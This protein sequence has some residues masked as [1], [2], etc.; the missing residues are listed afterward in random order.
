[1]VN[2]DEKIIM[3][4]EKI[5]F[6]DEY[7]ILEK[8]RSGSDGIVYKVT[9][10]DTKDLVAIKKLHSSNSQEMELLKRCRHRNIV[11]MKAAVNNEWLIMEHCRCGNLILCIKKHGPVNENIGRVFGQQI[12]EVLLYMHSQNIV[13]RIKDSFSNTLKTKNNNITYA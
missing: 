9:H 11:E 10:S 12:I 13:H 2:V 3:M 7:Q 1:R 5:T 8:I 4:K 6:V